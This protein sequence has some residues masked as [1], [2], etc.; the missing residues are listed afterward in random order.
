MAPTRW[1]AGQLPAHKAPPPCYHAQ[2]DPP[3]FHAQIAPSM[4]P[5]TN[6][7]LHAT[8]H[9]SSPPCFHAQIAP[10]KLPC[11]KRAFH[12]LPRSPIKTISNQK[13]RDFGSQ[14]DVGT[15]LFWSARKLALAWG[16]A[17]GLG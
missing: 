3:C 16:M 4:L 10:S 12:P 8:M 7:P 14:F 13:F 5:C 15:A 2:I 1:A 9:K 17:A 11:T 6:R